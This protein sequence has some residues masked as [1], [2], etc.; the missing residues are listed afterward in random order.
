M[1]RHVRELYIFY[2]T[3]IIAVSFWQHV[4]NITAK[5]TGDHRTDLRTMGLEERPTMISLQG[6]V[7]QR[8][9]A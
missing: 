5:S 2:Q 3:Y 8:P 6:T 7:S 4:A 9:D 1:N